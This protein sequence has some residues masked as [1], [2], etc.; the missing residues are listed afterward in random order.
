MLLLL[1]VDRAILGRIPPSS[2]FLNILEFREMHD[3]LMHSM[4]EETQKVQKKY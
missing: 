2:V 1:F 4:I 3:E